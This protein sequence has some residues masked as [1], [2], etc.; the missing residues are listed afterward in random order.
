MDRQTF[1]RTSMI[2][3]GV[4]VSGLTVGKQI[5][6]N[7]EYNKEKWEFIAKKRWGREVSG[8]KITKRKHRIREILIKPI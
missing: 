6:L 1:F 4:A 3:L 2:G 5:G 7:S 8:W